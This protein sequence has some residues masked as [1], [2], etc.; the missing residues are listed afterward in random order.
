LR[1]WV[2]RVRAPFLTASLVPI[3]L[4]AVAAWAR[5]GFFHLPHFLLTALGGALLGAGANLIN[6]YFDHLSGADRLN[7]EAIAPFTGGG[8]SLRLGL[9][10]PKRVRNEA[11]AH[12]VVAGLIGFYLAHASSP[13]VVAL[14]GVGV[15]AAV[16]YTA[17]LAPRGWGEVVL[18][19]AFGP[20][21]VLGGWLVQTGR[22]AW[23]PV[24]A[25]LP[26]AFLILNV[27]WINQFP[28]A[29]SDAL[30]GK[31]HWVVRLGR[32]RSLPVYGGLFLASY[33]ALLV[34][35]L[36]G[37]M[38][39][40]TLLGILTVPLARRA[41]HVARSQRRS[42]SQLAPA[43]ALTA[44]IHLLTGLFVALGYLLEGLI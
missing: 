27:L 19:L 23:E 13:W 21:M 22:L 44:Q 10:D 39:A 8:P 6:D 25:S 16:L 24:W 30:V 17:F 5:T 38:P 11:L 40:G 41:W 3:T 12:F 33:L 14:G 15:A 20:L 29:P 26:V 36:A 43:N 34:P 31:R 42:L 4:G 18:F 35:A 7:R 9:L 1:G 28:D 2:L 37:V 32:R